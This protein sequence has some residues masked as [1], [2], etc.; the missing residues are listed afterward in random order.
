MH[1]LQES[2]LEIICVNCHKKH[3]QNFES[4]FDEHTLHSHYKSKNCE[5]CGYEIFF[6]TEDCSG[7]L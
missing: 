7:K 5:H 1:S 3:N 6:K 2:H 4:K